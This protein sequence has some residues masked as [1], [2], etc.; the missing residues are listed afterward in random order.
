MIHW[1]KV[2]FGK[3]LNWI[4]SFG[5]NLTNLFDA[6][7]FLELGAPSVIDSFKIKQ[8]LIAHIHSL[9]ETLKYQSKKNKVCFQVYCF[10]SNNFHNRE[11]CIIL[12]I[13]FIFY[14]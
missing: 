10:V 12:F 2:F 9:F 6:F 5:I 7:I 14:K 8:S 13:F 11:K 4:E 1:V 3:R